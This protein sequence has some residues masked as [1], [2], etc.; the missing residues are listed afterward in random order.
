MRFRIFDIGGPTCPCDPTRW[1]HTNHAEDVEKRSAAH[2]GEV[3]VPL[4]PKHPSSQ[5]TSIKLLWSN[6]FVGGHRRWV[7]AA[8]EHHVNA[9]VKAKQ[10]DSSDLLEK[11]RRL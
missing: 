4:T 6:A 1:E 8:K 2:D 5:N 9:P 7:R 3:Q 10:I 11:A